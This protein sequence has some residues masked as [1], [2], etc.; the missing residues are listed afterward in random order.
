MEQ[1]SRPVLAALWMMGAVASFSLMAVAGR[2]LSGV[3]DTYELMAFRSL[4]GIAIVLLVAAATGQIGHIRLQRMTLHMVRNLF[5]FAG[6]NLWFYAIMAGIPLA[7]VFAFEFTT[8]IW[9][10]L[11]APVF[12]GERMTRIRLL[13]VLIG[14]VGILIVARPGQLQM[15]AGL[16]AA[17]ACVIGFIGTVMSTKLLSRSEA[18]MSI[19]F[20]MV[21]MQAVFGLIMAGYDGDITLPTGIDLAWVAIVACCGLGAHF[22]VTTALSLAPAS[23]VSPMDFLRLPVIAL[24]GFALYKEPL[25]IAVFVGGA[26]I[27]LANLINLRTARRQ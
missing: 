26:I 16:L 13:S 27:L 8:P 1:D 2:E 21:V 18:V 17:A 5:H 14:F 22:C 7:Q 4:I 11:L 12:L 24:I 3:L 15:S 9:V 10:T 25:E 6:Q 20:W 23:L 19:L